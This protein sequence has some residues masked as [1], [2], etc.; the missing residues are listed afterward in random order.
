[1]GYQPLQPIGSQPFQPMA[2]AQVQ[3][4]EPAPSPMA[5]P[6]FPGYQPQPFMPVAMPGKPPVGWQTGMPGGFQ[7]SSPPG[8]QGE[9]PPPFVQTPQ[10]G[11]GRGEGKGRGKKGRKKKKRR[12]PI[13]AR[14]AV[15]ILTILLIATGTGTWYYYANFAAPLQTIFNKPAPR[16]SAEDSSSQG[17]DVSGPILSGKRINIL[18]LGS[19]TDQ[20]FQGGYLAQTDIVVSIDPTAKSVTMLSIPRDTWLN[21]A[22]GKGMM[23]LDQA[24]FYGGVGLSRATIFQDFGIYINYYAWVGLNGFIGV[25]NT[26]GGVDI[27]VSHPITDDLYPDDTVNS[28]NAYAYKRVYLAPGPQHLDGP[29]ALEYVRSRHADLVGD[30]GR[31]ARQQQVLSQLKT[32]LANPGILTELP[33]LAKDLSGYVLTDM[34]LTDILALANFARTLNQTQIHQIILGPGYSRT[35]NLQTN[36]NQGIQSVVILNC[37]AVIPVIAKQLQLGNNAQ[38]NTGISYDGKPTSSSAVATVLPSTPSTT[39]SAQVPSATAPSG[40]A[41]WQTANQIYNM[42]TTNLT[43]GDNNLLGMRGLLDLMFTVVC[44]SPAAMLT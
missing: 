21:A 22:E 17:R 24:Y 7:G 2:G 23:K 33:Q 16:S 14:V 36:T 4:L 6:G 31:S 30:F 20:K 8:Y 15:A 18:L 41:V 12:F 42:S 3:T 43:G 29:T 44:E 26:V 13:W 32:K 35:E 28:S 27:D 10:G 19:D 39:A 34:G 25:I 40:M 11:N 37:S 9:P 5:Y 1:M 38:C